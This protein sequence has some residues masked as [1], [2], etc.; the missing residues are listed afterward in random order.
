MKY[1]GVAASTGASI[2]AAQQDWTEYNL[3]GI[4]GA[5]VTECVTDYTNIQVDVD[6]TDNS[7]TKARLAAFIVYAMYA[8][9]QGRL[10]WFDV[11]EYKSAGS[12]VIKSAVTTLTIDNVKTGVPLNVIDAFQLRMDNGDSMVEFSTNT[13]NWDNS[14]DAVVVA[15]GSGVTAQDKTDI[16]NGVAAHEFAA[17]WSNDR[18]MRKLTALA[19]GKTSGN[20]PAGG[21][22]VIRNLDDTA[23]EMSATVD[24]NGNRTAVTVGP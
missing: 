1:T 8:E 14:A 4:S 15:V 21:T 16:I 3:V 22:V 10:D 17:G 2:I 11:I 12:A 23:N 7:T 13:I 9:A 19:L 5:S 6:D 20:N 18:G 24:A